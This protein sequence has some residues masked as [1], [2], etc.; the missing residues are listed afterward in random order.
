MKALR[1]FISLG[2]GVQSSTMLLMALHERDTRPDCAIFSDPGWESKATYAHLAYLESVSAQHNFPIYR[3]S[4]GNIRAA[5]MGG[6]KGENR[7]ASL[8]MHIKNLD[9]KHAMLR[10][11]CTREFKIAPLL[12]KQR[13]LCGLAYRQKAPR[14]VILCETWI[15]FQ[16]TKQAECV[17]HKRSG[18]DI[19]TL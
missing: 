9:G 1:R 3:V 6:A 16:L 8:P 17:T 18:R 5:A 15:G 10:R 14:G 4:A 7:F 19:T 13:Q 11:Q 2:A 12:K